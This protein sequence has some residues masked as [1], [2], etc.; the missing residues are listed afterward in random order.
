MSDTGE[1]ERQ[2]VRWG[3][4]VVRH[5][6]FLIELASEGTASSRA[7]A[8]SLPA[9]G[10]ATGINTAAN[11]SPQKEGKQGSGRANVQPISRY[12][13]TR[14]SCTS[15]LPPAGIIPVITAIGPPPPL[16]L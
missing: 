14:S 1:M 6:V 16:A 4:E 12:R 9:H 10:S 7:S 11:H 5:H 15:S 8:L 2:T 13:C 3:A